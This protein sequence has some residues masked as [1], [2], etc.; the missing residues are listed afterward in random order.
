VVLN[1]PKTIEAVSFMARLFKSRWSRGVRLDRRLQQPGAHRRPGV[2]HPHSI[3]AYAP[4]SNRSPRSPRTSTSPRPQGARGTRFNSE[5]V[6]Y[7]Y[8]VPKYSKN[9]DS[10]KKFLL[11]LVGN[12]D[13]AMY[14][15][16]LYNSP[17]SSTP[18]SRPGTGATR[19]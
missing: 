4:R 5:H 11:D 15:S 19:P 1:N 3:S 14:K 9:V 7:C 2:L 16:E 18:P 17:P 8:V 10:A 6:I 13:Q 12:Y